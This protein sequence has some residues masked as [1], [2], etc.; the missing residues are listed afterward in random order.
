MKESSLSAQ[1]ILKRR[2]LCLSSDERRAEKK[3][4]NEEKYYVV[5]ALLA[6][7]NKEYINGGAGG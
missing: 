5:S 2:E 7:W 4:D 6:S 3:G 1:A